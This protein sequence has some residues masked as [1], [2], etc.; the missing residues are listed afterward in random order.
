MVL[1]KSLIFIKKMV[2][3]VRMYKIHELPRSTSVPIFDVVFRQWMRLG[4]FK[5]KEPRGWSKFQSS[6]N[7]LLSS[8]TFNNKARVSL[9]TLSIKPYVPWILVGP[10]DLWLQMLQNRS[11]RLAQVIVSLNKRVHP[12]SEDQLIPNIRVAGHW[13]H[14]QT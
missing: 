1:K 8:L 4:G 12:I 11:E 13:I 5:K 3:T 14:L 6:W 7:I 10:F 2:I 9:G